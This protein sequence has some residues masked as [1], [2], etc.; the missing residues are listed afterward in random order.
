[1]QLRLLSRKM[2]E[3]NNA[4]AEIMQVDTAIRRSHAQLIRCF[5][6][7]QPDVLIEITNA[8][9]DSLAILAHRWRMCDIEEDEDLECFRLLIWRP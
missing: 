1:M 5:D 6:P 9:N 8:M 7:N 2:V 4:R 3:R